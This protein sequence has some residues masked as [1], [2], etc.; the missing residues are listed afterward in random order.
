[1]TIP[2]AGTSLAD[3]HAAFA[4]DVTYTGAGL[5]DE[6]LA[7]VV[8]DVAADDFMG[9]G[10]GLRRKSFEI[11]FAAFGDAGATGDPEKDDL[12][13]DG[14]GTDWRVIEPVRRA[15]IEA[16]VLTVEEEAP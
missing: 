11:R 6:T 9:S 10:D 13:A 1:M 14:D 16:W 5:T 8:S 3:I 15:D 7:A 4:E 12:I 2:G